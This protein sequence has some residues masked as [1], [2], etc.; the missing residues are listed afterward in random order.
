MSAARALCKTRL[1]LIQAFLTQNELEPGPGLVPWVQFI[2]S[3]KSWRKL[4]VCTRTIAMSCLHL[5]PG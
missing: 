3:L 5:G 4:N 2:F 1:V